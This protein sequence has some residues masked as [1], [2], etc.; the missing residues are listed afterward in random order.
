[1]TRLLSFPLIY[2]IS[3]P[4]PPPLL[5]TF[6]S[7]Y[8]G[9]PPLGT[10]P[11]NLETLQLPSFDAENPTSLAQ[12]VSELV[13][14]TALSKTPPCPNPSNHSPTARLPKKL[15]ARIQALDFVE[16]NEMLPESWIPEAQDVSPA[17]RKPSRRA[18][19]TDVLDRVLCT[20]GSSDSRE[21]SR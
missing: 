20:H 17:L 1:M 10:L 3:T 12:L 6:S 21:V 14:D 4:P 19:I 2:Y 8:L 7:P 5:F 16:M 9:M 15:V 11:G 13:Q 18:P